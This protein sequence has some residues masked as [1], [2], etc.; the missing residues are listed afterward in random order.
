MDELQHDGIKGM[1]WGIRR[2]QYEDGSLT[3]EGKV[4]YAK[5]SSIPRS[6]Q[7]NITSETVV[8][9]KK[10]DS[11]DSDRVFPMHLLSD[12]ERAV[13]EAEPSDEEYEKAKKEFESRDWLKAYDSELGSYIYIKKAKLANY[14]AGLAE[15]GIDPKLKMILAGDT[16]SKTAEE[17]KEIN[18]EI[19]YW[20]EYLEQAKNLPTGEGEGVLTDEE[21]KEI[22][23]LLAKK[24][25]KKDAD[26]KKTAPA[27]KAGTNYIKQ[28]DD[29]SDS[30]QHYGILG[31]RWGIRR[32]QNYD[33]TY[34]NT[35]K[36]RKR[37]DQEGTSSKSSVNQNA[38]QQTQTSN[39]PTNQQQGKTTNLNQPKRAS[40][41]TDQELRDFLSRVDMERRYND[42]INPPAKPKEKSAVSKFV[43]EVGSY[44]LKEVAKS[45]ARGKLEDIVFGKKEDKNQKS[46]KKD[47]NDD[48]LEK[49]VKDLEKAL[50]QGD[51]SEKTSVVESFFSNLRER[52]AEN[53]D[54][55]QA[56][57]ERK[58]ERE[59]E[60]LDAIKANREK[61]R[62]EFVVA[63]ETYDAVQEWLRKNT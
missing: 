2:F 58:A 53:R 40:E 12:A 15:R 56:A 28:S 46:D 32:Y 18:A 45:W 1:H 25:S 47:K 51:S 24:K 4:R 13:E 50:K 54:R 43:S 37:L 29:S 26:G 48:G 10:G 34:T 6:R 14:L 55:R 7:Q 35:G 62:N 61:R 22:Q 8:E 11:V 21:K 41:M 57:D 44:A 59:R 20:N 39:Q 49:R 5:K 23:D 27:A 30:L 3:P 31:M 33:G 52:S 42:Y 60:M 19:R 9:V 38:T 16:S 63:D 36:R 17:A